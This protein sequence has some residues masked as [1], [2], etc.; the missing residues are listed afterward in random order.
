[1]AHGTCLHAMTPF[2][3][4]KDT[5]PLWAQCKKQLVPPFLLPVPQQKT[6]KDPDASYTHPTR[7]NLLPR[8]RGSARPLDPISR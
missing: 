2:K 3:S 5:C 1:M 7:V 6:P 8:L 4:P